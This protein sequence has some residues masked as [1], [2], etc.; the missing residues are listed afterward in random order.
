[1]I[2]ESQSELPCHLKAQR[3][4]RRGKAVRRVDRRTG[5]HVITERAQAR[6]HGTLEAQDR[7]R[8]LRPGQKRGR[9]PPQVAVVEARIKHLAGLA[10]RILEFVAPVKTLFRR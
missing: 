1:M 7:A 9:W 8:E 3:H 10:N 5:E 2:S 4:A 6:G